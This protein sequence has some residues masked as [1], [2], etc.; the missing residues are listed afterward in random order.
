[1]DDEGQYM[2]SALRGKRT[3]HVIEIIMGLTGFARGLDVHLRRG[4]CI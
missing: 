2:K 3:L 4:K 1:M